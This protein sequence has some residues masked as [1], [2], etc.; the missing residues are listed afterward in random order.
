MIYLWFHLVKNA[1]FN[2]QVGNNFLKI[3]FGFDPSNVLPQVKYC[4]LRSFKQILS[5]LNF[6][7]E[8]FWF[9]SLRFFGLLKPRGSPVSDSV[10]HNRV[11]VLSI[12]VLLLTCSQNWTCNLQIVSLE[13][14]ETNA[15][16]R[17]VMCPAGQFRVIFFGYYK[18]NVLTK[19]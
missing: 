19:F 6:C 14:Q 12:P 7:D 5:C 17:Y 10:S 15:Y 13:A 16:N 9:L 4:H 8:A 3:T 18:L 11:Q 1:F 2:N